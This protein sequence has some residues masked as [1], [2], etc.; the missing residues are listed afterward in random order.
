MQNG[1][2]PG[3]QLARGRIAGIA[4]DVGANACP[5]GTARP[6]EPDHL[7]TVLHEQGRGARAEEAGRTGDE[8][9]H[10]RR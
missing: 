7:M 4:A 8:D 2:A 9:F 5:L 10:R 3:D 6:R 1:V